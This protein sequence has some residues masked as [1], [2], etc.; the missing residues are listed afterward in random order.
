MKTPIPLMTIL[1]SLMA[2]QIICPSL[3]QAGVKT[4]S[5]SLEVTQVKS[6]VQIES[7]FTR[8]NLSNLTLSNLTDKDQVSGIKQNYPQCTKG[9]GNSGA[10]G[11]GGR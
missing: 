9:C 3:A 8:S 7:N 5:S 10:E 2:G 4:D 1:I 11:G 6:S